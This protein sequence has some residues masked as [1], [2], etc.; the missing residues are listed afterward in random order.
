MD[1]NLLTGLGILISVVLG[2]AALMVY[3]KKKTLKQVQGNNSTAT[4][5][6]RDVKITYDLG[7]KGG[8]APGAGG[9]GGAAIGNNAK[10]GDGGTGG[11]GNG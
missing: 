1:S 7:G 10:G 3:Q 6:G 11:G 4:Q 2:V 9:G 8:S 5:Y